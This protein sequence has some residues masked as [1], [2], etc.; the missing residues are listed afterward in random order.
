MEKKKFS[1]SQ[2]IRGSREPVEWAVT[3]GLSSGSTLPTGTVTFLFTDIQGSTPLWESHPN[4][5]EEALKTH[6][7]VLFEAIRANDGAV[8]KLVGDEFQAAFPTA[9]QAL[10][11]AVEIQR[12]LRDAAWNELG[13]LKS[14]VGLHTGEAHLDDIGDEYAVC[15]AK[16]RVGRIRSAA[17]GG[18]ILL[19]RETADLC[20]TV[21]PEGV[22]LRYLGEYQMKGLARLEPIYQVIVPGL[23]ERFP[24]LATLTAPKNNLPPELT[25]FI[26]REKETAAVCAMLAKNRLVTL[27]GV[28]GTG[29]TRLALRAASEVLGSFP[30]GIWLVELAQLAD[31]VMVPKAA[32]STLGLPE[33]PGKTITD[34]LVNYLEHKTVLLMLDNCEHLLNACTS[35]ADW[36]LHTC[37]KVTILATSREILGVM[38]E[39]PFLVPPLS[40]PGEHDAL[41]VEALCE[42]DAVRLFIERSRVVSSD[43]KLTEENAPVVVEVVRRLDGIPL[44]IELAAARMRLLGVEQ[45]AQRLNDAFRLLTGG[46]RTAL[47]RHQALRA[48]IDWSYNLLSVP[49]RALLRRLSVF[50]GSWSLGAAEVICADE[51]GP[52]QAIY[53]DDILNLHNELVDKSLISTISMPEGR[54]RFRMLETVRQYAHEK[55]VDENEAKR[56]RTR[57]LQYY[58]KLVESLEPKLR[59]REQIK[60]L[61][62]LDQ[63]LDNIRLALEWGLQTDVEALLQLASALGIFWDIRSRWSESVDWLE[64]GLRLELDTRPALPVDQ[65]FHQTRRALVR[66]KALGVL[67]MIRNAQFYLPQ[68][69]SVLEESLTLYRQSGVQDDHDRAYVLLQLANTLSELEPVNAHRYKAQVDEALS[70]FRNID[71]QYGIVLGLNRSGWI[72]ADPVRR[73]KIHQEQLA[74]A[75]AVGNIWGIAWALQSYGYAAYINA[76]FAKA[77]TAHEACREQSRLLNEPALEAWSI[78]SIGRASLALG[79]WICAERCIDKCLEISREFGFEY[80]VLSSLFLKFF[81]H[82]AAGQV[83]L[84]AEITNEFLRLYQKT[85][86]KTVQAVG[87]CC[88]TILAYSCGDLAEAGQYADETLTCIGDQNSTFS[89]LN[90]ILKSQTLVELGYLALQ[91]ADAKRA[92]ALF[93]EG[94]QIVHNTRDSHCLLVPLEAMAL[95]HAREGNIEKAARLFGTRWARGVYHFLSP[96]E[97]AQRDNNLAELKTSL[98]DKLFDELYAQGQKMSI[99]EVVAYALEGVG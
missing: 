47:P 91:E 35:L 19:S 41:S 34:T 9:P 87:L 56:L 68:A 71:D 10:R 86:N 84:A 23:P 28:G 14:R 70:I 43:F 74:V 15:P 64:K 30:D 48:S 98:G 73:C 88:R 93:R 26:G 36:L 57:H 59:G 3:H 12:G 75:E 77:R 54:N 37:P 38:G 16:N 62:R 94:L 63:E 80:H 90:R 29:K 25:S 7:D 82:N 5:M 51:P 22:S 1:T 44:A 4:L 81:L 20:E 95:L 66:A 46:A 39:A 42:C 32:A 58:V 49:E 52:E 11:A 89:N 79:D 40:M 97:R 65:A 85:G 31:P 92:S 53:S 72:E 8:F 6:N 17:H 33:V 78:F 18:Q 76:D 69:R 2:G 50:A 67:G 61:N 99:D 21:L 27:T 96:L 55:L 13:A 24:P 45:I 60:T 83:D